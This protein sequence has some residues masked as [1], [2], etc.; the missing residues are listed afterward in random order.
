MFKE[1]GIEGATLHD[2]R[3]TCLSVLVNNLGYRTESVKDYVGHSSISVTEAHY[4]GK[5]M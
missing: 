2:L 1:A 3:K 4:L 5:D